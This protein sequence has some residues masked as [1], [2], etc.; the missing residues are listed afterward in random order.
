MQVLPGSK[1]AA[2]RTFSHGSCRGLLCLSSAHSLDPV[3][4]CNPVTRENQQLPTSRRRFVYCHHV[5]TGFHHSSG[6]YKTLRTEVNVKGKNMRF[7]VIT[8]GEDKWRT[9][10]ITDN[11]R[12]HHLCDPMLWNKAIHWKMN[13][14]VESDCFLSS[15]ACKD[16]FHIL[17]FPEKFWDVTLRI[18]D[19]SEG[20]MSPP[21]G[22]PLRH[23][24]F[25]S[26]T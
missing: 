16:E 6:Q 24:R 12:N 22:D 17:H 2:S 13:F 8:L 5:R 1:R 18:D 19:G 15:D 20:I 7:K 3:F 14:R 23:T 11:T 9:L 26:S 25:M 21:P 4:V 10:L